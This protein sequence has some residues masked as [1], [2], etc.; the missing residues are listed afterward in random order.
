MN[1]GTGTPV[2]IGLRNPDGH[3]HYLSRSP[4]GAGGDGGNGSGMHRSHSPTI[5]IN[6]GG[7]RMSRA[8]SPLSG[9]PNSGWSGNPSPANLS[10]SPGPIRASHR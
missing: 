8:D 6:K 4:V 7:G 9:S 1:G 5:Q 10:S 2:T 3:Q